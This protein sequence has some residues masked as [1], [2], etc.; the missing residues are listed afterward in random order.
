VGYIKTELPQIPKYKKAENKKIL[1]S[2]LLVEAG[3][4]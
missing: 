1:A 3:E 4:G 2:I